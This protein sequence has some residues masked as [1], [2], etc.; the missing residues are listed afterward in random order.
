M[1]PIDDLTE[2]EF[3][4][5]VQ[6]A[7]SLPDAPPQ[8]LRAAVNLWAGNRNGP[9][10]DLAASV[11][12]L[13]Q[14]VL[15]FDSWARPA[16]ASGMRS[17]GADKRH[18]LFNAGERDVDL[19]INRE[20]GAFILTGQVLGPD[21][22]GTIELAAEPASPAEAADSGPGGSWTTILDEM[23][24]FRLPG[25]PT[26]AYRLTLRFGGD[27]VVLTPIFVGEPPEGDSP[28]RDQIGG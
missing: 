25:I 13:I 24:E 1:K 26:G 18:L 5:L 2:E 21:G 17:A 19:R 27:E 3:A 7:V 20:A 12:T 22:A 4:E 6:R 9:L 16:I 10:T 8:V 28:P 14:A 11:G 15:T 23:G